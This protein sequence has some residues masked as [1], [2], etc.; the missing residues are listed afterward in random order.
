MN[1]GKKNIY[2]CQTCGGKIVTIDKD[3]GTTP[4][5]IDCEVN[6]ECSGYMYS[7]FYQVDQSLEPEF[8]WYMPDSLD[9]YPE[10]FRETMKEHIDKSG[11]DIRRI[12]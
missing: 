5:M 6:K 10:E 2:I 11:L 9:V 7:S 1:S 4:F 3:E 12:K 8:E